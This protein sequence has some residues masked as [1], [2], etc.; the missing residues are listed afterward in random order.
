MIRE[1]LSVAHV[2]YG[3]F[4]H[5]ANILLLGIGH[6]PFTRF[7]DKYDCYRLEAAACSSQ[8]KVLG[9]W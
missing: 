4:S 5:F 6:I 2:P 8:L 7:T 1:M 9:K 3:T